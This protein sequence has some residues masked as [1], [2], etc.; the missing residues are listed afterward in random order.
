MLRDHHPLLTPNSFFFLYFSVSLNDISTHPDPQAK[1][2]RLCL[3][4]RL[5]INQFYLFKGLN[6]S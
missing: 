1:N 3:D 6:I 5:T 4:S 2:Q